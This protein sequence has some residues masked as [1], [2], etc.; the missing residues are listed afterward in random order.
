MS[1][2]SNTY[3]HH[4]YR[5][6]IFDNSLRSFVITVEQTDLRVSLDDHYE[7]DVFKSAYK[8]RRY[9]E[10]YIKERPDFLTSLKPLDFD[11]CAPPIIKDMLSYSSIVGVGP[12]AS[13]AGAIAQYV[14]C[15]C[16]KYSQNVI[17]ENGG[18]IYLNILDK[19]VFIG[20]YAGKSPLSYKVR[21]MI[22]AENTPL[23]IC[24][25]SGKV[26]HSLSFGKADAVCVVSKSA[27][28]SDAAATFLC[29]LVQNS[30]DIE[31]VLER[32]INIE[33]VI[34]LV[35]IYED[36]LGLLGDIELA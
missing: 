34:G 1:T 5:N 12:M 32:G 33:G 9:I 29:N 3:N 14:G 36:K 13:V 7:N 4:T 22:R 23:G 8:Y 18:D 19:N 20:V 16:L 30:D 24:T 2:I 17:I 26:G 31:R 10:N 28:L 25:S 6:K 35:I 11:E 15:D 21:L 27:V